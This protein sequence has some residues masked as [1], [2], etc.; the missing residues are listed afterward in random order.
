MNQTRLTDNSYLLLTP[1]PLTTSSTVREAMLRDWCTW[2]RD[3]NELVQAIRQKLVRLATSQVEDYTS[4]LMQGSGTFCVEAV[5]SSAIP[6]DGK[7]LVLTNGAYGDRIV[8]MAQVHEIATEVI[9]F[10]EV[11]K[12]DAEAL[13]QKLAADATITH[14]AVVHSETTTGM[15][16][17]IKEIGEVAKKYGKVY[18]V[19][20]M[21]SFGGIPLDAAQLS[22]DFLISSANKCIQ[23]VPGFGFVVAKTSALIRCRGIARTLSLDLY[24][25]WKTMEEQNGKWRYTSPTHVVRAFYQA[26]IEL[27]AEGGVEKRYE[28]YQRNQQLLAEGMERIGFRILLPKESQSPFI[29]SFYY[30]ESE[31]FTFAELYERLKQAGFVIYPGKI[32]QA[33]TFRI[34]NIGEVYPEDIERLI[35]AME[36]NR[37][38]LE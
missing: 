15:L 27:E 8:E 5:V 35:A 4:V 25:Q 30:P 3:Y 10:G 37:F 14:V 12:A 34:G 16:N 32:S 20:A 21:S 36:N 1:G 24:S 11:T 23:G 26:L 18:I 28:R 2:D 17:P 22:I 13:E 33:D 31:A 6:A 9:D 19:D 29:T 7:L 38:W